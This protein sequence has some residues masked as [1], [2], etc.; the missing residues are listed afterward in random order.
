MS[1]FS[2]L[3]EIVKDDFFDLNYLKSIKSNIINGD[4]YVYRGAFD[5]KI[6]RNIFLNKIKNSN[7]S[8]SSTRMVEGI[9][10]I[11]YKS[12]SSGKGEYT[13]M[14]YS[15][16]FFPWNTDESGLSDLMQ[17]FFNQVIHL[18]NYDPD[19]LKKNTPKDRIIQRMQLIYYPLGNGHISLHKDPT[20]ITQITCGV[21]FTSFGID[22]D[23]GG[24]YV[25]NKNKEKVFIDHSIKAGDLIL[26]FNG[27]YHGVDTVSK[28]QNTN[29]TK[30]Y[31]GRTFLNLSLLESHEFT[32]RQTTVGVK[33][34]I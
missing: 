27:L 7:E 9:D 17:P 2:D 5:E 22:Y 6:L 10:N 15:W 16:Y 13:T 31:P 12:N 32:S 25:F 14:D 8:A 33:E 4:I 1:Y 11:F 26:F 21:Y 24:F 3:K 20:N 30:N 18:N 29:S 19:V 28:K 34:V 23:Q